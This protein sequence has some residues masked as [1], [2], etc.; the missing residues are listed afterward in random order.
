[1]TAQFDGRQSNGFPSTPFCKCRAFDRQLNFLDWR[2]P[3]SSQHNSGKGFSFEHSIVVK[4]CNGTEMSIASTLSSAVADFKN[5]HPFSNS[6]LTEVQLALNNEISK[7]VILV[8]INS[9]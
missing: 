7:C 5:Y 6:S 1:M 9:Q 8:H 2:A 4:G 3:L